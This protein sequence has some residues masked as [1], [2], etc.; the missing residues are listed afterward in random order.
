MNPKHFVIAM[1]SFKGSI[2]SLE[3]DSI[4]A[5]AIHAVFPESDTQIFP[6]ADG[7]EGTVDAL[8]EGLHGELVRTGVTGPLGAKAQSRF[9]FLPAQKTAI[10]EMAD[11]AGLPMV[12]PEERNPMNTTTYGLGEL[13]LAAAKRG[14]RTFLIG[15]GGSATNDAGLG[16]M[17]ALGARFLRADGTPAGIY[18]KDVA[19]V[20]RIDLS[21]LAPVLKECRFSIACDVTNPLTGPSG[22]SAVYGP[23]KGATPEIVATM[24]KAIKRFAALAETTLAQQAAHSTGATSSTRNASTPTHF[25]DLPGAGAAGGLGF[26]FSAFLKATLKP[27]IDLVLDLLAIDDA[28]KHADVIITGEGRM[29]EQTA[30]GKAPIG[31]AQRAKRANPNAIALAFCGCAK[32]GA[33]VVNRHGIDAYFP[34]LHLPMTV[35][36]A[37][38]HDVTVQNLRQ[39][40]TQALRVLALA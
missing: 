11:A 16:M 26:A 13:I 28:L 8:V 1:D 36:E 27:G 10:I 17:T 35:E 9:G 2:T 29:D 14:C 33:E 30:M 39:T 3:G 22:C 34:I 15:L 20:A 25:A 37:M 7:G 4:V 21:G 18:G 38:Q 40:V 32:P 24:D 31:I 5:E 12:P 6:L 19:E 23:Q